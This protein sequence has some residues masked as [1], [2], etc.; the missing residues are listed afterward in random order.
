MV[1]CFSRILR[2]TKRSTW[3]I[4]LCNGLVLPKVSI[5]L[6]IHDFLFVLVGAQFLFLFVCLVYVCFWRSPI[7]LPLSLF[8]DNWRRKKLFLLE[9][10]S[11]R[12]R[13]LLQW[14]LDNVLG[15]TLDDFWFQLKP[16]N[17]LFSDFKT[18][19]FFFTLSPLTVTFAC[20]ACLMSWE[21]HR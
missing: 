1:L 9:R 11:G 4:Y 6:L 13:H 15:W 21:R 2:M 7:V 16:T 18:S 19:Q 12:R 8:G 5:A 14:A 10:K 17:S 20:K 3:N